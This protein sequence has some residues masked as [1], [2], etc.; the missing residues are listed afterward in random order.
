VLRPSESSISL[1][2]GFAGGEKAPAT[3]GID[4]NIHP[5]D[6]VTLRPGEEVSNSLQVTSIVDPPDVAGKYSLVVSY[7]SFGPDTFQVDL[8]AQPLGVEYMEPQGDELR[9]WKLFKDRKDKASGLLKRHVLNEIVDNY[10]GTS[11]AVEAKKVL[12]EVRSLDE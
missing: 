6:V 8:T 12:G 10:P 11:Y 1:S 5:T 4:S 9:A 7:R 2:L 3:V